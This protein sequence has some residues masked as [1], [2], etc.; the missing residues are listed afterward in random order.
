M[1]TDAARVRVAVEAVVCA[2]AAAPAIGGAV[3][4]VTEAG[5]G[6]AHLHGRRV[7]VPPVDGCGE[8]D[9]C[10]RALP[11]ACAQAA[12]PAAA[13]LSGETTIRARWALPLDGG[14]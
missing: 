14:L 1:A 11:F 3:G 6:A 9:R 8:C 10:R 13:A 12:W 2:D 4:R 5:E 7:L